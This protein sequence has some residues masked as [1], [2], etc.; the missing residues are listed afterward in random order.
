M[1]SFGAD[2]ELVAR[3]TAAWVEGLQST[4]VAASAKHFPGHGDTATDSHLALPVVDLSLERAAR[5]RAGAVR[6]GDRG[7]RRDDHDLAHPAAAARPTCRRPSRPRILEELLRGELGF[8]GVIVSDALDMRGRERS[9]AASRRPRSAR[10]PPAATCSA[11]APR[12][13]TTSSTRSRRRSPPRRRT[14]R[15]D[16][17][18]ARRR[19]RTR[20]GARG[21]RA[22]DWCRLRPVS[23][24]NP[25]PQFDLDRTISAFDVHARRAG[26][27]GDEYLL[28][29]LDTAANIAVGPAP[30]GL[31][32][33]GRGACTCCARATGLPDSRS[34]ARARSAGTTTATIG[35]APSSTRL[36]RAIRARSSI[37]M[38]WPS[39]DRR[40]AD[41]ATFGASRHVGSGAARSGCTG[42]RVEGAR[43]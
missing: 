37:D 40:Y 31:A 8:T 1:R 11:S 13:P 35:H 38:G 42:A 28:V 39:A 23:T 19:A 24:R 18:P 43:S 17:G 10:S 36:G 30:W 32:G 4:G 7:G 16:R 29:Q 14:A 3:H 2:P 27:R 20:R 6:G 34:A 12:T 41:V 9:D 26:G 21:S 15:L 33:R 5:A 22:L 25:E